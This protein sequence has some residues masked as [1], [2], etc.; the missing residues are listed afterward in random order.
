MIL[1]IDNIIDSNRIEA[2]P[3]AVA[4]QN[5]PKCDFIDRFDHLLGWKYF[6]LA[7]IEE[8]LKVEMISLPFSRDFTG[9]LDN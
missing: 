5:P 4:N 8:S 3:I 2:F 6:N 9:L 7:S 1:L